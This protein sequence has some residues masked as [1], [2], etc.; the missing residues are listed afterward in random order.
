MKYFFCTF[1]ILI[2]S[3]YAQ[4]AFQNYGNVQMHE[5]AEVGF[6]IDL[7][8]DGTFNENLGI[9]GFYNNDIA[10]SISGSEVPRFYDMEVDVIN[11]LF[12]DINTEVVNSVSYIAGDVI[13][14]REDPSVSIDYLNNSF[15]ILEDDERNTDGYAS[16]SGDLSFTFPIGNNDKLRP[17][18]TTNATPNTIVKAAYFD[19]NPNFPSTFTTNFNTEA[20]EPIIGEVSIIEFW[21]FDGPQ[22]SF[23]TLTWNSESEIDNL[24]PDLSKLRVVGWHITDQ[25]WK[26]LGN[27]STTGSLSEGTITSFLFNPSDYEIIT[28]GALITED[29]INIYNLVSPNDD[30]INDTF[31]IDGIEAFNN[32]LTIFNRWGSV[33]YKIDNYK[34]NWDGVANVKHVIQRHKKVPVGTYY[35]ILKLKDSSKTSTGWLYIIY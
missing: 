22:N 14:P 24:V 31:T 11:H 18:I 17:L 3:A 15:Y 19:E 12:L 29:D 9:A 16:Y 32:E 5:N 27:T 34:N 33:V 4:P 7:I 1:L 28:F 13:T 30:G 26:D 23:V 21:D 2:G 35:Y 8:N 25:Q 10:L 20:L 6:H